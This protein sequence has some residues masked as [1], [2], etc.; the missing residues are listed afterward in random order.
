MANLGYPGGLFQSTVYEA[1][2]FMAKKYPMNKCKKPKLDQ[3][4]P[5]LTKFDQENGVLYHGHILIQSRS[6]AA[7]VCW[8]LQAIFVFSHGSHFHSPVAGDSKWKFKHWGPQKCLHSKFILQ[9]S[10]HLSVDLSPCFIG[11]QAIQ[12][13]QP[14]LQAAITH[15]SPC[16]ADPKNTKI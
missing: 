16:I 15:L 8:R 14:Q 4:W 3:V 10:H 6:F 7:A 1:P 13:I 5:S 11:I 2:P 9:D 12:P